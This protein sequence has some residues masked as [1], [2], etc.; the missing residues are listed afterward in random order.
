MQQLAQTGAPSTPTVRAAAPTASATA[1]APLPT[2]PPATA[3]ASPVP[4]PSA[5]PTRLPEPTATLAPATR[6][7]TTLSIS[8]DEL[9]GEIK[10]HGIAGSIPLRNPSVT[11]VAPDRVQVRGS[12]LVAIFQVPVELEARLSVNDR[13]ALRLSTTRVDAVGATLPQSLSAALGQQ[14]DEQGSQAVQAA[15]PAGAVARR[16]A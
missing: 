6:G 2:S 11:L 13:G 16:V 5:T 4:R 8:A 9:D 7:P 15:L 12:V 1:P 3:T 14:L 10:R